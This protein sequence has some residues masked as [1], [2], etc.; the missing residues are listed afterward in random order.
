MSTISVRRAFAGALAAALSV[1]IGHAMQIP[2]AQWGVIT[3]L[4]LLRPGPEGTARRTVLRVLGT[5]A[6]ALF[7]IGLYGLGDP[8]PH[9]IVPA[10]VLLIGACYGLMP[11]VEARYGLVLLA[12]TGGGFGLDVLGTPDAAPALVG[13]RVYYIIL[14]S[15]LLFVT[16]QIVRFSDPRQVVSEPPRVADALD[17]GLRM[18][19]TCMLC[20]AL[21]ALIERPDFGGS[22]VITACVLGSR[23]DFESSFQIG[24]QRLAGAL[25]GGALALA[26]Y[27]FV[28]DLATSIYSLM[29][30]V[31]LV[32]WVVLLLIGIPSI[33][34][35][36]FQIG[37]VFAW[38]IGDAR[39]PVG[40]IWIP[41]DRMAQVA[42]GSA[43]LLAVYELPGPTAWPLARLKP[44]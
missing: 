10:T 26:Y 23:P 15:L 6:G 27:V 25:L 4:T 29:I 35:M 17:R 5:A 30:L 37:F 32:S 22:L 39:A 24:I 28:L 43:V 31:F 34:Y 16:T 19:L 7:V 13:A 9:V 41:L 36:V 2:N 42:L 11:L 44:R 20:L 21:A 1:G 18:A 33:S 3:A 40:D 38:S 8:Q 14:G 12:I